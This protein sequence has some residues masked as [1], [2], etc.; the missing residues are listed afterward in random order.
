MTLVL[1][2]LP[3]GAI[4][5][6]APNPEN[7]ICKTYSYFNLLPF[8]YG[9]FPPFFTAILT[10]VLISVIVVML[11]K[12]SLKIRKNAFLLSITT[13]IVSLLPVVLGLEYYSIVGIMITILLTVEAFVLMVIKPPSNYE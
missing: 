9:N 10:C 8:G 12:K 4:L 5:V 2:I 11:F 3:Y 7:R 1:E 13:A 6:F